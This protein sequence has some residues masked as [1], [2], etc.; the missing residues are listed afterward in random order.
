[1]NFI[2]KGSH[3]NIIHC[4][5]L[6]TSVRITTNTSTTSGRIH[7]KPVFVVHDIFKIQGKRKQDCTTVLEMKD[8]ENFV[9]TPISGWTLQSGLYIRPRMWGLFKIGWER[10]ICTMK[11][12]TESGTGLLKSRPQFKNCMCIY[13]ARHV[14]IRKHSLK[15]L[16]NISICSYKFVLCNSN[17]VN[18]KL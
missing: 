2:Q 12:Q 4:L 3:K 17:N 18:R 9:F 13:R 7:S 15:S 11:K 5:R 14:R 1:M 10:C 8:A 16:I 6:W